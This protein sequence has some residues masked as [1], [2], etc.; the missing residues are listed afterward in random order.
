MTAHAVGRSTGKAE[1]FTAHCLPLQDN[2]II[3]LTPT[4]KA[5]IAAV[6]SLLAN[7]LTRAVDAAAKRFLEGAPTP[8]AARRRAHALL[9]LAG[10]CNQGLKDI[11]TTE[12]KPKAA[13]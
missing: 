12:P 10:E 4:E 7:G 8:K 13:V 5:F 6:R 1:A 2:L 9:R 11:Q 3:A